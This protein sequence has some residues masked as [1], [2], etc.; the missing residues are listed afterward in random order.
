M[1]NNE[2]K[3]ILIESVKTEFDG[4]FKLCRLRFKHSLYKG[5]WSAP[6][7]REVFC[8][9]E[10]VV[11]LLYDSRRQ[12][13]VLV[14]QC[15]PGAVLHRCALPESKTNIG[16]AINHVIELDQAWLLEPVAGMIDAGETPEQAGIR[17]VQEEAGITVDTL[18]YICQLYPSPGGCDEMLYLYAAD[19][20]SS[21]LPKFAGLANHVEDIKVVTLSYGEAKQALREAR[22]NVATTFIALQWLFFQRESQ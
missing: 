4:F 1:I 2:K 8:R 13:V 18:E 12:Q 6:I 16:T 7:E 11:V 15:R 21:Q 9:G 3:Q 17:E 10:A 19:I 14:E 22:F 5:N 20:D